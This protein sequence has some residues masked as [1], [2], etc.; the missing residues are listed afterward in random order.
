MTEEVVLHD[1]AV[2]NAKYVAQG[3]LL[4]TYI[5]VTDEAGK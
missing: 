5:F 3:R 4:F 1:L 2:G